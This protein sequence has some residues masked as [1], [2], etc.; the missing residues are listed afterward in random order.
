MPPLV[1]SYLYI[2]QGKERK[3][4]F[5]RAT[6][7]AWL[8][9]KGSARGDRKRVAYLFCA[10]SMGFDD[11]HSSGDGSF[12]VFRGEMGLDDERLVSYS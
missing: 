3:G 5:N 11:R 6:V 12:V 1:I 10:G 4:E 7:N 2:C 9:E 8:E